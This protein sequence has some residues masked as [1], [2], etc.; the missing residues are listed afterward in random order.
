LRA[1]R[2]SCVSLHRAGPVVGDGIQ[3]VTRFG[4]EVRAP[5]AHVS[6]EQGQCVGAL[7]DDQ[8]SDVTLHTH[9]HTRAHAHTHTYTHTHTHQTHTHAHTH[10]HTKHTHVYTHTHTPLFARWSPREGGC[11]LRAPLVAPTVPS[12][13]P[14]SSRCNR[15]GHPAGGAHHSEHVRACQCSAHARRRSID[16]LQPVGGLCGA[17]RSIAWAAWTERIANLRTWVSQ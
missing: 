1:R 13:T 3:S 6:Q 4:S 2:L 17:R 8:T 7:E 9:T 14:D 16:A 11:P 5:T 10:T 15:R 12:R